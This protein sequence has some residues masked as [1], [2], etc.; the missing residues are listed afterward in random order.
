M[1]KRQEFARWRASK[2]CDGPGRRALV[3]TGLAATVVAG[4]MAAGPAGAS[5]SGKIYAC[6]SDKTQ[7]LYYSKPSARCGKGFTRV[8]W[9]THGPQGPQGAQGAQGFRGAKGPQGV[10]GQAGAIAGYTKSANGA[11]PLPATASAHAS[12][13]VVASV[14]PSAAASYAVNGMAV[15]TPGAGGDLICVEKT[16]SS[17]GA[18]VGSTDEASTDYGGTAM[19]ATNGILHGGP[20]SP[21]REICMTGDTTKS[22]KVRRAQLTAVQLSTAHKLGPRK[23]SNKFSR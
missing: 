23:P 18:T 15:G 4:G 3:A 17:Q 9:N 20:S 7:A 11:F 10:Q 2:R 14:I 1:S 16:L 8:S 22:G 6:Y 19:V 5:S 12:P 13:V 21:I